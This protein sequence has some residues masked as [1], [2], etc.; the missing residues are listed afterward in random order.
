MKLAY[1]LTAHPP[2]WLEKPGMCVPATL[3]ATH[4]HGTP[5]HMDFYVITYR[6]GSKSK[7]GTQPGWQWVLSG[8][9]NNFRRRFQPEVR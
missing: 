4:R 7:R 9:G 2:G 6:V 1:L 5:G 8:N 3:T